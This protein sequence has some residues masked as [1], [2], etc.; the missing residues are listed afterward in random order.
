ML[1]KRALDY[2]MH[3]RQFISSK[4]PVD[5][6]D[7]TYADIPGCVIE[8]GDLDSLG[9]Y[10][11]WL[12]TVIS[13]SIANTVVNFRA[14]LNG[15]PI[16]LLFGSMQKNLINRDA[17]YSF[18]GTMENIKNEDVFRIQCSA[19]QGRVTIKSYYF[20]IEGVPED[21]VVGKHISPGVST[22]L[23]EEGGVFLLGDGGR[24]LL[25]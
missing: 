21:R 4:T 6:D 8:T 15:F 2:T 9:R 18:L 25:E 17:M 11:M 19:T 16:P 22:Y 23:T 14:T 24:M 13:T 10:Q 5:I 20:M 1:G 7:T 12:N 3:D